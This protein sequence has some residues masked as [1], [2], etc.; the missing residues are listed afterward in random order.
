MGIGAPKRLKELE[1]MI[2]AYIDPAMTTEAN[3]R[4][5]G[6]RDC[7]EAVKP[8]LE[9]AQKKLDEQGTSIGEEWWELADALEGL[10]L[11]E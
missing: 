3:G 11:E 4:F 1:A 8:V 6:Y 10:G 7:W 9:A 2:V 5:K